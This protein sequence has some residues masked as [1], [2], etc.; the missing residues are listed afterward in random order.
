MFRAPADSSAAELRPD[1]GQDSEGNSSLSV[2][3]N[4]VHPG[5]PEKGLAFLARAH[6]V[7]MGVRGQFRL[8]R[9]AAG[10]GPCPAGHAARDSAAFSRPSSRSLRHHFPVRLQRHWRQAVRDES[11]ISKWRPR[12]DSSRGSKSATERLGATGLYLPGLTIHASRQASDE[13]RSRTC[14]SRPL[15][16]GSSRLLQQEPGPGRP[17]ISR[18]PHTGRDAC[19]A[20]ATDRIEVV[21]IPGP[22]A[23]SVAKCIQAVADQRG[24]DD[25]AH[26]VA[27]GDFP[28]N[29]AGTVRL[30]TCSL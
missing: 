27:P 26:A 13:S 18:L 7:D 10:H 28:Q 3:Q 11:S 16:S 2:L 5:M 20:V 24:H 29:L 17:C 23:D 8:G 6:Q 19:P 14:A 30:V 4:H 1:A 21:Q 25:P 9:R 22:W 15:K 12:Q